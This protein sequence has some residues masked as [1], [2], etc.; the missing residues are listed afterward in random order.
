MPR[1][2]TTLAAL[3]SAAALLAGPVAAPVA[4]QEAID[5]GSMTCRQAADVEP[6]EVQN[7]ILGVVVG[8]AM[9]EAGAPFELGT[10]NA[11]YGALS[12]ICNEAPDAP[13]AEV[14]PLLGDRAAAMT[15]AE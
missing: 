1:T 14:V 2:N 9:G 8:Y 6:A 4:A 5:L 12:A 11:W 10:V 3:L 13:L 15:P 7:T